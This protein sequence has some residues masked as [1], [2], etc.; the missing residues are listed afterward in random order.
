MIEE[1]KD[2]EDFPDCQVNNLGRVRSVDHIIHI[3]QS[4]REVDFH[5]KGRILRQKD[6]RG[7]KNVGMSIGGGKIQ[8]KQ[9]H[10]LVMTAFNPVPNMGSLQVNHKDFDKSNNSL[11]NLEWVTPSENTLHASCDGRLRVNNQQGSQNKSSKL[12]EATVLEIRSLLSDYTDKEIAAKY[13]VCRQ[14]INNIRRRKS[15]E[16]YIN[17]NHNI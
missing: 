14:T 6:I 1:W 13:G 8:T 2:L 5:S 3:V 4:Y 11:D 10:R 7:Y 17:K 16:S 15:L 12:D 9:V